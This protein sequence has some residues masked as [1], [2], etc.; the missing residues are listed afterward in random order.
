MKTF[1]FS[2]LL[3]LIFIIMMVIVILIMILVSVGGMLVATLGST[4]YWE[5]W[6][7]QYHYDY[8]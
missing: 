8:Q 2:D 3:Q 6:I 5:H 1:T 7:Y 4:V